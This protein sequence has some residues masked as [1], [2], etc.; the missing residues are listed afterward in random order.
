M[1]DI[2][3]RSTTCIKNKIAPLLTGVRLAPV[4][5]TKETGI[6]FDADVGRS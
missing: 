1:N 5:D 6:T 2:V 3:G 4:R